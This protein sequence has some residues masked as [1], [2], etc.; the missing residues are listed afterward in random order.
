LTR[1]RIAKAETT[2]D[3]A[4]NAQISAYLAPMSRRHGGSLQ[5]LF[6]ANRRS[7]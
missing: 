4:A 6:Q 3:M 5:S 1:A 7:V 2:R